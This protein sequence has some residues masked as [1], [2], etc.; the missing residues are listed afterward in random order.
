MTLSEWTNASLYTTRGLFYKVVSFHQSFKPVSICQI[1]LKYR[2]SQSLFINSLKPFLWFTGVKILL[3]NTMKM[4]LETSLKRVCKVFHFTPNW[5][6]SSF[7]NLHRFLWIWFSTSKKSHFR[8][9]PFAFSML[10]Y[11]KLR[12]SQ[13]QI[14]KSGHQYLKVSPDKSSQILK[15]V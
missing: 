4:S 1:L 8:P 7:L 2:K 3:K 9:L 13:I 6:H 14:N 15:K 10:W 11:L 5:N 12:P